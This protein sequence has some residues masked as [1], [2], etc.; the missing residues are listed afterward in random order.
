VQLF[1]SHTLF[2]TLKGEKHMKHKLF[3]ALS[4][5]AVVSLVLA[6]CGGTGT[7]VKETV[8]VPQT[9]VVKETVVVPVTLPP[10]TPI[11]AE[12]GKLIAAPVKQA[13]VVDGNASDAVWATAPQAVL[14]IKTVGIPAYE[15]KIKSVYTSDMVYFLFQYPDSNY[16][17]FRH[18]WAYD[19]KTKT[20]DYL[21]DDFGDE[22]EFGLWWNMTMPDYASKGCSQACHVDKMVAPTGTKADDWRWNSVRSNV[23]GWGRDFIM[24]DNPEAEAAGGFDKD[25][26]YKTNRGY[27]NNEQEINGVKVP[28]YWKPFS[29][30]GGTIVGDPR[31]LLQSEIDAGLAKKITGFDPATGDLTDETGAVVP[32]WVLIPGYILSQP[33]GPSWNDIAARGTWLDGVWTVEMARK[34]VTGHADDVQF[35]DLTATYYFDGYIKTRQPGAGGPHDMIPIT[36]FVFAPAK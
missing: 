28:A 2:K 25:E 1:V 26:G 35:S 10:A 15:M 4:A 18:A 12:P 24:T 32:S 27:T 11:A 3:L 17:A 22:D 21:S 7:P 33:G 5:L 8:I 20:W 13:P 29:G 30:A 16:E 6:A 14:K 36:A 23:I 19:P 31:F 9:Q 34:L